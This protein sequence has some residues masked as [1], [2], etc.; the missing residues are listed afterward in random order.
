MKLRTIFVLLLVF[1][2]IL[3]AFQTDFNYKVQKNYTPNNK[4]INVFTNREKS[5][6]NIY[7]TPFI[8]YSHFNP[9]YSVSPYNVSQIR[10]AYNL[11]GFYNLGYCGQGET[12]AI[13]DAYGD[14]YLNYDI[15]NFDS[16]NGLPAPEMNVIYPFGKPT[17]YNSSWGIETSTDVEWFHSIA[18]LAKIDLVI[19]PTD[20]V[21]ALQ[22]SVNYTVENL[23]GI[24]EISMSWGV[25][26]CCLTPS[27]L[28]EYGNVFKLAAAKG[29]SV[30]AA[31]G[32]SGAMD[33][34]K[35]LSV[36]FP[37]S[38][39][40][41]TAVGGT[42]LNFN[43]KNYT[44]SG[45]DNS[46]GG[47][48]TVFSAPSYQKQ[49][50]YFNSTSR[51]VPDISAI[52]N[53]QDGVIVFANN[54]EYLIGGTSL[55]TPIS[56]G[57]FALI[58]ERS[59]RR[60]GFL[61]PL[62]YNI[63]ESSF[64]GK[65]IIPA[66]PGFNGY[67][68]ATDSWNPVTGLGTINAGY[69]YIV[70]M[71]MNILYGR[72]VSYGIISAENISF[73]TVIH[74]GSGITGNNSVFSGIFVGYKE[75]ILA[76]VLAENGKSFE[77]VKFGDQE[78]KNLSTSQIFNT[79]IC[80]KNFTFHVNINSMSFT[81]Q[82]YPQEY[83]G[84]PVGIIYAGRGE[85]SYPTD[86]PFTNF[87][88]IEYSNISGGAPGAFY[89]L[90]FTSGDLGDIGTPEI[91]EGYVN[92]T[93]SYNSSLINESNF[94]A[95]YSYL[96]QNREVP[97]YISL[98][99]PM[100]LETSSGINIQGMKNEIME[101]SGNTSLLKIEDSAGTINIDVSVPE[102]FKT[103][104]ETYYPA[105]SYA[106]YNFSLIVD[107]I[108]GVI[109]SNCTPLSAEYSYYNISMS[110]EGFYTTTYSGHFNMKSPLILNAA[111]RNSSVVVYSSP[112]ESS[113]R[114]G[115]LILQNRSSGVTEFNVT[116]AHY[117]VGACATYF[118]TFKGNLSLFP[119]TNYSFI[120][121][122]KGDYNGG[123]LSG[124]I[125]NSKFYSFSGQQVPVDGV[126]ISFNASVYM[127]T[128]PDGYFKIFL[129]YG[130]DKL[131]I[132]ASDFIT[133]TLSVNIIK[134]NTTDN[135]YLTP[136]LSSI[137]TSQYYV[138]IVR[139]LPLMF[140]FSFVSWYTNV[141]GKI[142]YF[143]VYVKSSGSSSWTT[144]RASGDSRSIFLFGIY[145]SVDYEVKVEAVLSSNLTLN[146]SVVNI[147][148]NGATAVLLNSFIY[149]G[150]FVIAFSAF[151]FY[152]VRKNRKKRRK[153]IDEEIEEFLRN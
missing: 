146:S 90:N 95:P 74:L 24:D 151:S 46:G 71:K 128:L 129:P 8:I 41:L 32:D 11:S 131:T 87:T 51:G 127:H 22:A 30:F 31:S 14:L 67:Y 144:L 88:S 57:I 124:Y 59:G 47:F 33:G 120:S 10:S 60:L 114:L 43:G 138:N 68:T 152:R 73:H 26:E 78:F 48:S 149:I 5:S 107:G 79:E 118:N 98:N 15:S 23:S 141:Q 137:T 3:L 104:A 116:P 9:S 135:I 117:S 7:A 72:G 125:F 148:Y 40:Y 27:L 21:N 16:T 101:Y 69:F 29:I 2:I 62:L 100:C 83:Y 109:I 136:S 85:I 61:D 89:I 153:S 150:I 99:Y 38:D 34:V 55:A 108:S 35:T 80:V 140:F 91:S 37:A 75:N 133:E 145:P 121:V 102:Y 147:N 143:L 110:S 45:W 1:S 49:L 44:Q 70:L 94:S 19:A 111:E 142:Q 53:P 76:G 6:K 66:Y 130:N 139:A 18:P 50:K 82:F 119:G 42:T 58:S 132:S 106:D 28:K 13:V 65:A 123:Y 81:T 112:S 97:L 93:Y 63:S 52:A 113:I 17:E 39:P 12:I 64:Y 84:L 134:N 54:C 92:F 122:L 103:L 20:S 56:A 25:P 105:S 115:S 4:S 86:L 77:Y 36:N 126:N 96:L